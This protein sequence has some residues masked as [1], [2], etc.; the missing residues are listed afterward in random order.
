MKFYITGGDD[1]RFC[2]Y[3]M[4]TGAQHPVSSSTVHEAGVTSIH[5]NVLFEHLLAS[6]RY[7]T[8]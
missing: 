7:I 5:S 1:S 8:M 4:R 2:T 6:G 3:D